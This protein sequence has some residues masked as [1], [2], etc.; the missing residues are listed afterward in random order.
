MMTALLLADLK[1]AAA[2]S[3]CA[4]GCFDAAHVR[5]YDPAE[6]PLEHRRVPVAGGLRLL[7]TAYHRIV[8]D[9]E[10]QRNLGAH[11]KLTGA[12][13]GPCVFL[14]DACEHRC[15]QPARQIPHDTQRCKRNVMLDD[16]VPGEQSRPA[17]QRAGKVRVMFAQQLV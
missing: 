8:L 2:R 11:A 13:K 6:Q 7:L 4:A 12:R 16:M 10:H 17:G 14:H 1:S 9:L 15:S 5:I 3:A